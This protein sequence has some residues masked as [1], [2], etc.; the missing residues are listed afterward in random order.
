[1]RRRSLWIFL[2]VLTALAAL[3]AWRLLSP[4]A[5]KVTTPTRGPAVEAVYATGLVEPTVEIRIAP[6]TAGRII[7][8][9]V[10]EGDQVRKGQLLARLDDE[11]L[12]A[13]VR[14]LEAKV[15]Y[16]R[17]QHQRNVEL[18]QA[19]LISQESLDRSRTDLE[20]AQAA[21]KRAR[22]QVGFMRLNAPSD[23]YIIRRDGEV[24][25]LIPAN[26]A[27]FYMAG[28]AP[29]RITS[30]VDEEDVPRVKPGQKVLIY[31]DA[32]PGKVFEG[33]VEQV[34]PRGNPESRSYRVRIA[35]VDDPPLRIGMTAETNIVVEERE[36]ALLVPSSSV[37]NGSVW[38]VRDGHA[39]E[40]KVQIGVAGPEKTEILDGLSEDARV[41]ESPPASLSNGDRVRV[42]S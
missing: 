32:F 16:A 40:E 4:P 10:D 7:E 11:D 3:A 14:E 39:F 26:Q 9:L 17:A 2:F 30:D 18:R 6:R 20:A 28:E 12:L 1:M 34:T 25:E 42:A 8:R 27:I 31:S 41:I 38:V 35:L 5:V 19:G 15:E 33:R 13:T 29:L 37:V 21:V 22:E 24:G 36:N 23:G